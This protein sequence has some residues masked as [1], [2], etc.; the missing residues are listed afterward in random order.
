M[1][2]GYTILLGW[3]E[4]RTDIHSSM[5]GE[6]SGGR[7]FN[8]VWWRECH[9]GV[10]F[11]LSGKNGRQE[12]V[13]G[14][15]TL[16]LEWRE[17]RA[18]VQFCLGGGNGCQVN[19]LFRMEGMAGRY[20]ILYGWREWWTGLQFSMGGG[21]RWHSP[22]GLPIC[23]RRRRSGWP[24][25]NSVWVEGLEC[26]VVQPCLCKGCGRRIYH[27]LC[28]G[29]IISLLCNMVWVKEGLAGRKRCGCS[30]VCQ[31]FTMNGRIGC[32]LL[33]FIVVTICNI[34]A[35]LN[36]CE[37]LQVFSSF[38]DCLVGGSGGA[39]CTT[40]LVEGLA[41]GIQFCMCGREWRAGIQHCLWRK[42]Y[43]KDLKLCMGGAGIGGAVYNSVWVEYNVA[44]GMQRLRIA[45]FFGLHSLRTA[46]CLFG[47]DFFYQR[48]PYF[49]F[50]FLENG[51]VSVQNA[52]AFPLTGIVTVLFWIFLVAICNIHV[53]VNF[54]DLCGNTHERAINAL[55][56]I[57][58]L[59]LAERR[60]HAIYIG[61]YRKNIGLCRWIIVILLF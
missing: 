59:T 52:K 26:G 27:S 25:Y 34:D 1:A 12:G 40:L 31:G 58:A 3:R 10:Q 30:I 55:S 45:V 48:Q 6:G 23:V 53:T 4:L 8:S 44:G 28:G 43:Q 16:L 57:L 46:G 2:G 60:N 22:V 42:V 32:S 21:I 36:F 37:L 7:E 9:A 5:G 49:W 47:A 38:N 29:P 17:W 41:V 13:A 20:T 56:L 35:T 18:G 33:D 15:Y 54:C 61:K 19:N 24:V 11:C 51:V 14:E 39:G 50:P